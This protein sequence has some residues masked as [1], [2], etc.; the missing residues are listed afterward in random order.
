MKEK[1]ALVHNIDPTHIQLVTHLGV[2][3]E[4]IL[5]ATER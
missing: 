3:R 1:N 4:N 5:E 2:S